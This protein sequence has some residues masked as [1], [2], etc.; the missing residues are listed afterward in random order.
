MEEGGSW[1]QLGDD[2]EYSLLAFR[3]GTVLVVVAAE[4]RLER[5]SDILGPGGVLL[6]DE[7]T[8]YGELLLAAAIG[9]ESE[10]T[11]AHEAVG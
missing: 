8:G 6:R 2:Q 9:E 3:A 1:L 4:G 11:D 5:C 7:V 10:V